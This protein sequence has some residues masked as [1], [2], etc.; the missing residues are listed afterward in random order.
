VQKIYYMTFNFD[1]QLIPPSALAI[2]ILKPWPILMQVYVKP[3]VLIAKVN[4]HVLN[5]PHREF[6]IAI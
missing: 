6:L 5:F 3:E 2:Y 4:L 1:N